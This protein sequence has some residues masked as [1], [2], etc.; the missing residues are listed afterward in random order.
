ME[1]TASPQAKATANLSG[2]TLWFWSLLLLGLLAGHA[3]Q[4]LQLFG[5]NDPWQHLQDDAPIISGRHPLHLYHGFLGARSFRTSHRFS[6]YDPAFQAGMPKTPVFDSGSRPAELFLTIAGGVY[7]PPA[8]KIG[9]AVCCLLVPLLVVVAC[10]GVGLGPAGTC[11]ATAASILV[12][13]STPGRRTLEAGDID[14]LLAAL[15]V[16]AHVGLLLRFDRQPGLLTWQGLLLTACLGWFAH[17]VLFPIL[18]PLLLV[19]YLSVGPR[20][21]LTTWHLA[22]AVSELAALAINAFWLTDWLRHWWLRSPLATSDG[23]L[24]HRTFHTIW[25]APQW[26]DQADRILGAILL[27]SAIVGVVLFNQTQQRVTA[28]LLGLGAAG[29]W[30]LAILGIA[31][32][33]LGRL[34]TADL[35]VPALWFAALP[36]AHAWTQAFR[37]LAHVSGS[38][39]RAALLT[40]ALLAGLVFAQRELVACA[41]QHFTEMPRLTMGLGPEREALVRMLQQYTTPEAR[42]LWEDRRER[43]E[44]S[45]WTALLPLLT[46]RT[47][48]GGIDP[49]GQI[50]HATAGLVDQTLR[51]KLLAHWSDADLDSY[52][53][54]YNIGWIVCRSPESSARFRAWKGAI[55]TAQGNDNGP[56]WLFTVVKA[57]RTFA[58]KGQAT[59]L[60]MDSHHITLADVVPDEDGIVVL[61]LHYQTGL[62]AAPERVLVEP[63][64]DGDDL[65]CFLRL[66]MERPVA[67]VTIT[68]RER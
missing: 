65:I 11:L 52:C 42:V 8:Y 1:R 37:L 55:E 61:S 4:S 13:W 19:Y 60:H 26:G 39:A 54:R 28:R 66:R 35:M 53:R 23:M 45:R 34:G 21:S 49:N 12:W 33:P 30:L 44:T 62:K 40:C 32:E 24:L 22:L 18:L 63:E 20:H 47:F 25:S 36:A 9:L 14:L 10:W 64:P 51:G 68:W 2:L 57:P 67:R 16:L 5:P 59:V 7:H 6:C 17:P 3:W 43:G 56:V 41:A 38:P 27:G 58:L 15:A 46:G 50:E 31:W 29:L 48:I